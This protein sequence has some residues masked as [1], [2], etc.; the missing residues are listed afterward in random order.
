M[1][2]GVSS[3]ILPLTSV[4]FFLAMQV[5]LLHS[6][7]WMHRAHSSTWL[8]RFSMTGYTAVGFFFILSGYILS[9]VYLDT[10]RPFNRR[11]FWTSRF[12]RAYPLLFVSLLLDAPNYFLRRVSLIGIKAAFLKTLGAFL[13]ECAL[14]QFMGHRFRNMVLPSWSLSVEAFFYLMFPFVAFWVWRRKGVKA[15]ALF[16]FFWGCSLLTPLLVIVSHP[17][18]LITPGLTEIGEI[19]GMVPVFRIF[20]FLAGIS[21]YSLQKTLE[22]KRTP[23]QRNRLGYIFIVVA[24]VL[25]ITSV[26]F[27]TH[28]PYVVMNNGLLLPVWGL[29]LLGLT[30]VRGWFFH[31]MSHR[32]LVLLGESSYSMY[33]LH[34]PLWAYFSRIRA[35]DTLPVWCI[36]VG[37]LIVV[38]V[39]SLYFLERPAR[40]R[41][42]AVASVRPA[43]IFKKENAVAH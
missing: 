27:A 20:E 16:V 7:V 9:Y 22:E 40:R 30:N 36:Y 39:A 19:I 4:R 33:L 17:T 18:E 8:G 43:I 3:P 25:F 41:I 11:A 35:I 28:I 38:S 42:L 6:V 24:C 15:L 29:I 34:W 12:A 32:Y 31:L 23:E 13:S 2:L 10:E 1:R 14:L 5:V 26:H 21:L 37:V